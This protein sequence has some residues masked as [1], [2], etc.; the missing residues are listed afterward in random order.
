MRVVEYLHTGVS[1]FGKWFSSLDAQAAAKVATA[2]YRLE[3][4]NF[5]HVKS[6]GQGVSEYRIDFGRDGHTLVVL[7]GGGSKKTQSRDIRTAHSMWAQ[8]KKEKKTRK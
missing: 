2:L 8:Y 5:S 7:L 1:V 3:Q 4:G 6:E